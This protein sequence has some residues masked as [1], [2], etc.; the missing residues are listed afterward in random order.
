MKFHDGSDFTADDVVFSF[1]RIVQPQ[2]TMQIYVTG[3]KDVVVD[4]HTVDFILSG[5]VPICYATSAT[6]AS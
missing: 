3:V 4:D 5:P 1:K 6:S 2:G